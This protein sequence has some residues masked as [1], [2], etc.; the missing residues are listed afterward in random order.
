MFLCWPVIHWDFLREERKSIEMHAKRSGK[1]SNNVIVRN[2]S[3]VADGPIVASG[4]TLPSLPLRTSSSRWNAKD[5][6]NLRRE[7]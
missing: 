4:N 3:D 2:Q 5:P 6:L 1:S 7:R